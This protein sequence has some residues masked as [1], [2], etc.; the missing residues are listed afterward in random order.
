VFDGAGAGPALLDVSD[1]SSTEPSF[2][3]PGTRFRMILTLIWNRI[4]AT[5]FEEIKPC[6][7]GAA[8]GLLRSCGKNDG[9][10]KSSVEMSNVAVFSVF[11]TGQ[12]GGC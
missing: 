12:S 4:S 3:N 7:S 8:S 9:E 2:R 11:T 6:T 1:D 5:R 10:V